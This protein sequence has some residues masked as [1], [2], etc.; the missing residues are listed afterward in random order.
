M[1][2]FGWLPR[3]KTPQQNLLVPPELQQYYSVQPVA[4]PDE[5]TAAR[6]KVWIIVGAIVVLALIVLAVTMLL[7]HFSNEPND[8]TKQQTT[9]A[10]AKL[11]DGNKV[12][13]TSVEPPK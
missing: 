9:H 5:T 4:V 7:V 6:Q 2:L 13:T 12:N 11:P 10:P 3:R 1:K 8:Q